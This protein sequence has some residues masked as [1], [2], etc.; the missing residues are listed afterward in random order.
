MEKDT[1]EKPIFIM[2]KQKSFKMVLYFIF[3]TIWHIATAFV[4]VIFMTLDS[5]IPNI[6]GFVLLIY[7]PKFYLDT[8]GLRSIICYNDYF[9]YGKIIIF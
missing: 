5:I 7:T 4:C 1:N 2:Q 6:I 3:V 8:I 9:I